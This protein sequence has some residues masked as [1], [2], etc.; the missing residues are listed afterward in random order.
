MTSLALEIQDELSLLQGEPH[1]LR[2]TVR[3]PMERTD[4]PCL[5]DRATHRRGSKS[6][7]ECWRAFRSV[8]K[9]YSDFERIEFRRSS[10]SVRGVRKSFK[11]LWETYV[12]AELGSQLLAV[13]VDRHV[14][15]GTAKALTDASRK[16]R[17]VGH[18]DVVNTF[19]DETRE[20][21]VRLALKIRD[22]CKAVHSVSPE[23]ARFLIN[24]VGRSELQDT[25]IQSPLLWVS[26]ERFGFWKDPLLEESA[27]TS[28]A[29]LLLHEAVETT[30]RKRSRTRIGRNYARTFFSLHGAEGIHPSSV[31]LHF[32]SGLV[33]NASPEL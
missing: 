11:F 9:R 13:T 30:F 2:K 27:V 16:K 8:K 17:T 25:I 21:A 24:A 22:A 14:V 31:Q 15:Y 29:A 23:S 12:D 32:K 28:L 5:S 4:Y 6:Y 18:L 33:I 3:C 19:D 20:H 10:H 26:E 7:E 1:P